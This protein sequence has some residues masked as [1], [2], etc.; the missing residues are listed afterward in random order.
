MKSSAYSYVG[1]GFVSIQIIGCWI[2]L[3]CIVHGHK[4]MFSFFV[5]EILNVFIF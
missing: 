3:K 2:Y 5:K 1:T 4:V